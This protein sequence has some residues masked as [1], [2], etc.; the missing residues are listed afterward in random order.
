MTD[1]LTCDICD[2]EATEHLLLAQWEDI[3]I[4]AR[5][6]VRAQQACEEEMCVC[7][8]CLRHTHHT[9]PR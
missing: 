9:A 5:C 3:C 7:L 8:S 1:T 4:C 6:F 2:R